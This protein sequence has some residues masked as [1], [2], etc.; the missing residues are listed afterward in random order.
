VK[1]T[2]LYTLSDPRTGEI[3]YLGKSDHPFKRLTI[4]RLDLRTQTHKVNWIRSLREAGLTPLMEILDEVPESQWEFWER[5]YI[6]VF[7]ATGVRLTNQA[8]GGEGGAFK[9]HR[10]SHE[11]RSQISNSLRGQRRTAEA[12]KRQSEA[13]KRRWLASGPMSE[14]YRRKISESKRAAR[15]D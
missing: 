12:R 14:E 9:G 10:H 15:K 11:S 1:T 2:F 4:H 3:R 13:A 7:R 5:E 8:E 6:R